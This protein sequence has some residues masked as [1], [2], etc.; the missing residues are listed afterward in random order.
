MMPP[1]RIVFLL[2]ILVLGFLVLRRWIFDSPAPQPVAAETRPAEKS[3]RPG[4]PVA[5]A[6]VPDEIPEVDFR[7][8][9]GDFEQ[10]VA[11]DVFRFYQRPTPVPPTPVPQPTPVPADRYH[12]FPRPIPPTPPPTPIVPPS[13]PYTVIGMFGPK[14]SPIIAIEEA[15]K[16]LAAR[17]GDT[18]AGRFIVKKINR[19]SVDIAFVGL[20]PEITRR[21]PFTGPDSRR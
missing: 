6:A 20:P 14:D 11:R 4:R 1:R 18:V 12:D 17:E 9:R 2:A 5:G 10:K 16:I 8:S 13:I 7:T 15:G 3:K 19:E 21:L